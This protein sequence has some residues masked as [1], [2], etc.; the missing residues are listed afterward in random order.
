MNITLEQRNAQKLY[1]Y[2]NVANQNVQNKDIY[3]YMK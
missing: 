3:F 1:N 2:I